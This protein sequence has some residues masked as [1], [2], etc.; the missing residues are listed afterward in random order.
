M[1]PSFCSK[2]AYIYRAPYKSERGTQVRDW[3]SE[4][5]Q[6]ETVKNCSFQPI[7]SATAWTDPSQAVTSQWRLFMPP[8]TDIMADDRV[9]VDGVMY[10]INGSPEIWESPTGAVSHIAANLIE[11]SL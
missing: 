2:T 4:S 1:L 11:W 3:S 10:A 8:G 5:V 7:T 6:V 9:Q